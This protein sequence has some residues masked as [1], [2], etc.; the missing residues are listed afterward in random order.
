MSRPPSAIPKS[1]ELPS[2][3][4]ANFKQLLKLY[5]HKQYKKGLKLAD[6]VLKKVPNHG[7]TL[8]MKGLF[9]SH[10]D[11]PAPSGSGTVKR[12]EEGYDFVK[13]GLRNDLTSHICWHVYGLMYRADKNYEEAAKCY[14][15]AL[16][17]DPNNMQILR[18]FSL[19][20]IQ[21]R[22]YEAYLETRHKLLRLRNNNRSYWIALA[23]SYHLLGRYDNAL[24]VLDS[25]DATFSSPES[26]SGRPDYDQSEIMLYRCMILEEMQ[27]YR[28]GLHYLQEAEKR[29]SLCDLVYVKEER[30]LFY[31]R[32]GHAH[33]AEK[34][35]MSL[36]EENPDCLDYLNGVLQSKYLTIARFGAAR[37]NR[38]KMV[39]LHD[40]DAAARKS[41]LSALKT[42]A[43]KFPSSNLLKRLPLTYAMAGTP[44]FT[45]LADTYLRKHIHKGV[46]SLFA[47]LKALYAERDDGAKGRELGRLVSGYVSALEQHGA[48]DANSD[49]ETDAI[50][51]RIWA[52]FFLA[53]HHDRLHDTAQALETIDQAIALYQE[54]AP[55][56]EPPADGEQPEQKEPASKL[57]KSILLEL[58][59]TKA[60][61]LKHAGDQ[62]AATNLMV[63]ARKLDLQDRFINTKCTKYLVRNDQVEDAK[64]TITMFVRP[65]IPDAL[66]DLVDMQCIWFEYECGRSHMRQKHLGKALKQF[67]LIAKHFDDIMDDQFDFH[68]YCLRKM[69]LR[70]YVEMLRFED[71]LRAHP[72]YFKSAQA[73]IEVTFCDVV[74]ALARLLTRATKCYLELHDNP[75]LAKN[76]DLGVDTANLSPQELK[77]LRSKQRKAELKA[78][79][80]GPE[81]PAT[82]EPA[83]DKKTKGNSNKQKEPAPPKDDD[84]N[85]LKLANTKAPLDEAVKFL[86]PLLDLAPGRIET[87]TLA[88]EIYIRQGKVLLALRALKKALALDANHPVVHQQCVRF[89][90]E[91]SGK[92]DA[93]ETVRKVLDLEMPSVF[94]EDKPLEQFAGDYAAAHA[95]DIDGVL[96]VA[97]ATLAMEPSSTAKVGNTVKDALARKEVLGKAALAKCV[98]AHRFVKTTCQND[99]AASEIAKLC[100]RQFPRSTYFAAAAP[101]GGSATANGSARPRSRSR[102]RSRP[103]SASPS[104]SKTAA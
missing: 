5:E 20:Q 46:P 62:N 88:F 52:L 26:A 93:H 87:H 50:Q 77:K 41:V 97:K 66:Q 2:K 33:S 90:T 38:V 37:N 82:S 43:D 79:Q 45:S 56:A 61:F 40:I 85:G 18:D 7:E 19:L 78:Q 71:T 21:M 44:E 36:L 65:D 91:V 42:L 101:S 99:D 86:V 59:M 92:T 25:Y 15:H 69:T 73:A 39:E 1:R 57:S 67:H 74:D 81:P 28:T 13:L 98:E 89:H 10:I 6:Q 3:E 55:K 23:I 103:G 17:Y 100:H 31:L 83:E 54:H 68:T 24:K 102:S 64:S 63:D 11:A 9:L 48:F 84:P 75:E 29:K 32:L 49:A 27:D 80:N 58:Y 60:R 104:K 70:S 47:N 14:S 8:A 96:A 34:V 16:K 4:A 95:S 22:N 94:G 76:Q 12:K 72:Y 35:Y 51:A 30:A 53:Q